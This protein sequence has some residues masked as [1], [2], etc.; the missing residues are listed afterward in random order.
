MDSVH[1]VRGEDKGPASKYVGTLSEIPR[2]AWVFV[3]DDD[4]EY[5]PTLLH[6]MKENLT[7]LGVYQNHFASIQQKTS[8][9]MIHGYVGL[10]IHESLLR[11]LPSFPLTEASRFVDDQWMSAYCW[12]HNIPI[13]PTPAEGYADIFAILHN[14]HEKLGCD[15]LSGLHSRDQKIRELESDLGIVFTGPTLSTKVWPEA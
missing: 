13:Y 4:Q 15:S 11:A 2:G 12:S 14:G 1:I 6:R 3:G 10:L 8:G 9:G 5:H 7:A